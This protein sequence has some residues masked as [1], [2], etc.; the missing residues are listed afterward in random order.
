[1]HMGALIGTIMAAN[2]LMVIIPGQRKVV[3]DLL[4]GRA[5]D[6]IHGYRGKQRSLHNNYLTLP[7]VFVMIA[8]HYPL[9][10]ATRW[11][12]LILALLLVIGGVV[13]HFYNS[14]HQ[15]LP[16][17]WWTWGVAAAC[18][19]AIVAL[20]LQGPAIRD[21]KAAAVSG[22]VRFAD[23]EEIVTSRC[24]MCH[25]AEPVWNGIIVPPKGVRLDTPEEIRRHARQIGLQAVA[26]AAMPPANVSLMTAEERAVLA[27]WLAN[28]AAVR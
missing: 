7:V 6:P 14:R 18:A 5:P 15:D 20:S 23:V 11:N 21:G 9:A 28:P 26:T 19:V 2:V 24:S 27:A 8:N 25:A 22:P 12:W 16:S 3:A 13:R 1:M 10:F 4:A 17:P